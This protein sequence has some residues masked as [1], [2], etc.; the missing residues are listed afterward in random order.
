MK[1]RSY[2]IFFFT[3]VLLA[4]FTSASEEDEE[5]QEFLSRVA[6]DANTSG[7]RTITGKGKKIKKDKKGKNKKIKKKKIRN[8]KKDM[9]IRKRK[10]KNRGNKKVK[11]QGSS[12]KGKKPGKNNG[13]KKIRTKKIRKMKQNKGKKMGKNNKQRKTKRNKRKK[14]KN[15]KK[16]RKNNKRNKK[17]G[18]SCRQATGKCLENA[19]TAMNRW[20]RV[21]SNY[22][23]QSIRIKGQKSLADKKKGK[24]GL[25]SPV[26]NQLISA[27]GGNKSALTC[28]GSSNSSGA[29]QLKNLTV[30]L[31]ACMKNINTSCN[32]EDFPK[33]NATL[34]KKCDNS[35]ATFEIE[36]EKCRKL[37]KN[38]TSAAACTCWNGMANVSEA[39][40]G[41][42]RTDEQE[43]IKNATK[44]C[45]EAFGKCRKFEDDAVSILKSC[46]ES[47]EKLKQKAAAL[48]KN[49]DALTEAKAKIAKTTGSS[50]RRRRAAATNCGEFIAL[51]VR[52]GNAGS[53]CPSCGSVLVIAG[54]ITSSADPTCTDAEKTQ[55][56]TA[57]QAV[58]AAI[59]AVSEALETILDAIEE[60]TGSK[61]TNEELASITPETTTKAARNRLN[62]FKRVKK[63]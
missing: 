62:I 22:K 47:S 46:S 8:N 5:I 1:L 42:S 51:A 29:A 12:K 10:R 23:K 52:L 39:V 56:S 27:G 21:V 58:A 60:A 50:G 44:K 19:V 18:K 40:V 4:V 54:Y 53:E 25:F 63:M 37:S 43:K 34:V 6:R 30:T 15:R 14:D 17:N 55:L 13:G 36:A 28:A 57:E 24:K 48:S 26:L 11:K 7:K 35:T 32:M 33:P 45:K 3:L 16:F 59:E 61:P 9:K 38:S 49:K 41:C 20:L 31:D 2:F